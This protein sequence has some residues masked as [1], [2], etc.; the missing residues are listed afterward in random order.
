M[1]SPERNHKCVVNCTANPAQRTGELEA[2]AR[3][4]VSKRFRRLEWNEVVW[5]GDFVADECLGLQPW[6]GPGGFRAGTFARPIYRV[7]GTEWRRPTAT[8]KEKRNLEHR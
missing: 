7:K 8:A 5:H 3:T 2:P 6:E 1:Q 4:S